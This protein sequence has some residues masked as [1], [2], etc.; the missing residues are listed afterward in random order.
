MPKPPEG[1][2]EGVDWPVFPPIDSGGLYETWPGLDPELWWPERSGGGF[3]WHIES[4]GEG[5]PDNEGNWEHEG[6]L[7]GGFGWSIG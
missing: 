6:Y 2:I 7:S 5:G 4:G 3:H 1:E